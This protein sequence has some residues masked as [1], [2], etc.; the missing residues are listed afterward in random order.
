MHKFFLCLTLA[1]SLSGLVS[2]QQAEQVELLRRV[3]R[4]EITRWPTTLQESRHLLSEDFLERCQQR[5]DRDLSHD[6]PED[7][8]RFALVADEASLVLGRPKHYWSELEQRLN[9]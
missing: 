8:C 1:V 4:A 9:P 2:A 6:M 5:I 3:F 7:A